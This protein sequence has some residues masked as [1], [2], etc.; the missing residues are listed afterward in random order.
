MKN[1]NRIRTI[2]K[3]KLVRLSPKKQIKSVM[4]RKKV[5]TRVT[6][7]LKSLKRNDNQNNLTRK[8]KSSRR[9]IRRSKILKNLHLVVRPKVLQ[10]PMKKNLNLRKNLHLNPGK[11]RLLNLKRIPHHRLSAK[12]VSR[13]MLR[14]KNLVRIR[15]INLI[16]AFQ[17]KDL[18]NQKKSQ[19]LKVLQKCKNQ[20]VVNLVRKRSPT[21]SQKS[22][23]IP[24][25]I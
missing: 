3:L 12:K 21:S 8:R 6:L 7:N 22:K 9:L 2:R 5:K 16:Q 1:R 19:T 24:T 23:K 15:R 4:R 25:K 20:K 11:S 10:K 13:V 18:A 17:P 14:G